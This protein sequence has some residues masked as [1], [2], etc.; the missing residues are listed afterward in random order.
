MP[1]KKTTTPPASTVEDIQDR[2]AAL[3]GRREDAAA[4]R[5]FGIGFFAAVELMR[6]RATEMFLDP[7]TGDGEA[8]A[9]RDLAAQI[10]RR[11]PEQAERECPETGEIDTAWRV[12][13]YGEES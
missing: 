8:C 10:E 6:E 2:R 13:V 7:L 5:A 11:Q 4:H 1:K 9:L 3:L 12:L